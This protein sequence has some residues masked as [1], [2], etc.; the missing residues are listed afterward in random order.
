MPLKAAAHQNV[1]AFLQDQGG[2]GCDVWRSFAIPHS[3]RKSQGLIVSK[4]CGTTQNIGPAVRERWRS[5]LRRI[6][7]LLVP[8]NISGSISDG[9]GSRAQNYAGKIGAFLKPALGT[10]QLR[11]Q[12]GSIRV[13]MPFGGVAK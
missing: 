6:R 4:R 10:L 13:G 5:R 3:W 8:C 7:P 11:P 2:G 9:V 1:I 12:L